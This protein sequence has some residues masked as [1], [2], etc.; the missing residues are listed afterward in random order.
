MNIQ[1]ACTLARIYA[2]HSIAGA[3]RMLINAGLELGWAA[4]Y[5]FAALRA[6]RA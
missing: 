5:V 1:T 6:Q 4:R 2:K 3:V